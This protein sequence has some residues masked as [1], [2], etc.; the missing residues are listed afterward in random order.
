MKQIQDH[1]YDSELWS[2]L[3]A[4]RIWLTISNNAGDIEGNLEAPQPVSEETSQ[5]PEDIQGSPEPPQPVRIDTFQSLSPGKKY[6][7]I[8]DLVKPQTITYDKMTGAVCILV[9]RNESEKL[10]TIKQIDNFKI[11]IT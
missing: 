9:T 11:Q 10:L 8:K 7:L 1:D 6:K 5:S 2:T 3:S 4:E